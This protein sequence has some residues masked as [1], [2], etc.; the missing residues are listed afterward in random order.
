MTAE[1]LA[2]IDYETDLAEALKNSYSIWSA[3]DSVRKASDDYENDVTN[4]L[5][6]YE[7][8]KIQRDAT[9]ESV[10]SSFRKLYKT[11]QEK[12]TAMTAA[13]TDLAQAQ[14]TFAVS[15]LQYNRGMISRIKF[16]EAQDT[17]TTAQETAENARTSLLTAYN[18]YQWAKRGVMTS[19]S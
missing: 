5:H 17:Y 13:Q 11:M 12:N 4:N 16:E 7:A 10:K 2:S 9:E 6:A 14:K 3:D 19:A 8:A 18:N 15:Q 1:Q